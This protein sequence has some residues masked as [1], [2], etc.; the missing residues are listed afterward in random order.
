MPDD[1][2]VFGKDL[3]EVFNQKHAA[4]SYKKLVSFFSLRLIIY[5]FSVQEFEASLKP[6]GRNL[7]PL[8]LQ[9]LQPHPKKTSE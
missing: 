4:K 9:N 2:L 1:T 8:K 3:V 5:I 7:T 6:P